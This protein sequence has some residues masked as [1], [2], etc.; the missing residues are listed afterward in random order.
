MPE[1][2]TAPIVFM[3]STL[4]VT[5][6]WIL[7]VPNH[8]HLIVAHTTVLPWLQLYMSMY[9]AVDHTNSS[10]DVIYTCVISVQ[11]LAF[12]GLWFTSFQC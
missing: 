4:D 3:W 1:S 5:D 2:H 8:A 11:M 6:A 10:F 7:S 9:M 12:S